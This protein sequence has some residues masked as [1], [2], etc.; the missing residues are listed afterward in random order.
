MKEISS[1][2][3]RHNDDGITQLIYNYEKK[4]YQFKSRLPS[5]VYG[6]AMSSRYD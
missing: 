6:I 4:K 1:K 5:Q 3:R 2:T